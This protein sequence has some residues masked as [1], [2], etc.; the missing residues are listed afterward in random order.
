MRLGGGM[1]FTK[2]KM[3]WIAAGLIGLAGI[4]PAAAELPQLSETKWLG[5]FVG[6][7]NRRLQFSVTTA[8]KAAVRVIGDRGDPVGRRLTIPVE[9]LVEE[10]LPNGKKRKLSIQP[11]TLESA[12]PATDKPRQLVFKGKVKGGAV[13]EVFIHEE[14]GLLSLGGRLLETGAVAKNPLRFSIRARI[15]DAYPPEKNGADKKRMEA[16]EKRIRKDRM[17][18][19]WT[20]GKK[21]KLAV[22]DPVDVGSK[23]INGPGIASLQVEL[24]PY[25]EKCLEF[26]ASQNSAITLSN[27]RVAPVHEGFSITWTADPAKDPEGRARLNLEVR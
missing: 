13:F 23:E 10:T 2:R 14:R 6:F 17:L 7:Q 25:A 19:K 12:Q 15:P 3:S 8:G 11:E 22:E 20:D 16:L 21:V 24:S 5:H 26:T 27:S 18:L 4:L 1:I 9:F